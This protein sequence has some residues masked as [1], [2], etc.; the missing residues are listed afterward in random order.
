MIAPRL[1]AA[2]RRLFVRLA[3][4]AAAAADPPRDP[5]AVL[6]LVDAAERHGVLPVVWRKLR[7]GGALDDAALATKRDEAERRLMIATGQSL[8]LSH[9]AARLSAAFRE[10]GIAFAIVKGEV[11]ARRLYAVASDRPFT[12]VDLL[13]A[14]DQFDAANDIL[15]RSG[16]RLSQ[17][18]VWDKSDAYREY[19]W[20]NE[21]NASLLVEV[22][23]DL[24]HY[25][26]LRA[27]LSF[28]YP[29]WSP[30]VAAIRRRRPRCS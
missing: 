29:K 19:K 14:E 23:G 1:P 25:P 4:P 3:D 10:A 5:A 18:A 2:E 16:F 13:V 12:D 21:Q 15:G 26:K 9:H 30:R 17:K 8:M 22:H 11:F 28:G 27:R 6:R 20:L 24:V 7:A